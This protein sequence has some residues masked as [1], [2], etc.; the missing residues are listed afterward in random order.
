MCI[1]P[2]MAWK[3]GKTAPMPTI[4]RP[5]SIPRTFGTRAPGL[6]NEDV[7]ALPKETRELR[8]KL[9]VL[10]DGAAL[11]N[12][13]D[14]HGLALFQGFGLYN[15]HGT[16]HIWP[17]Y[18]QSAEKIIQVK[19]RNTPFLCLRPLASIFLLRRK[20]I[21]FDLDLGSSV[22]HFANGSGTGVL[23][24]YRKPPWRKPAICERGYKKVPT[25]YWHL[26]ECDPECHTPV[27]TLKAH[28]IMTA[29]GWAKPSRRVLD[30]TTPHREMEL[31][32]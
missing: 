18:S 14:W 27:H 7:Y 6:F 26:T 10:K 5:A 4:S 16:C 32:E 8:L 24:C 12:E 9:A 30:L 22:G 17:V 2:P 28:W 29:R 31:E 23:W 20:N 13:I 25:N 1:P 3:A 15:K 19:R 11:T 21:T